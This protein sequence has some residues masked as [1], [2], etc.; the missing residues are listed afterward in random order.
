MSWSC[1]ILDPV[2]KKAERIGG[3]LTLVLTAVAYK[4]LVAQ[5]APSPCEWI[6]ISHPPCEGDLSTM[7]VL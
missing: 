3:S 2:V 6:C 5:M 7:L 1:F 4:Y